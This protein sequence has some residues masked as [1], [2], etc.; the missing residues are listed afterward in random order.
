MPGGKAQLRRAWVTAG[1]GGT[2]MSSAPHPGPLPRGEGARQTQ[3]DR[4]RRLC[5]RPNGPGAESGDLDV[6]P[7][8]AV[9]KIVVT[10]RRAWAVGLCS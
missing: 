2:R 7:H 4:A 6:V 1:R 3:R 10:G 8:I 5:A 9:E